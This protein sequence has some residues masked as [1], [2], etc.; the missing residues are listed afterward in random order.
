M[1]ITFDVLDRFQ[2]NKFQQAAQTMN[3]EIDQKLHRFDQILGWQRY[4][5]NVS[6][7]RSFLKFFENILSFLLHIQRLMQLGNS[8]SIYAVFS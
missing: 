4:L 5:L 8:S 3:I 1:T 2:E 7:Y 6:H